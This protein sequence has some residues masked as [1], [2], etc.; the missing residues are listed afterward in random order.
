MRWNFKDTRHDHAIAPVH[1]LSPGVTA[2]EYAL[3]A[4]LIA[5]VIVTAVSTAGTQLSSSFPYRERLSVTAR[6]FL[7]A[8]AAGRKSPRTPP[9][10]VGEPPHHR[11]GSRHGDWRRQ[12]I[13]RGPA[14]CPAR[15]RI[16]RQ[17]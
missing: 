7:R 9:S 3:I 12:R 5:V 10:I 4:S 16:A 14:C 15:R 8:F 1:A 11:I 2:I 17:P 13:K 6:A